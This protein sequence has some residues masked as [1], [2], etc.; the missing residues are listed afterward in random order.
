MGQASTRVLEL[1][2]GRVERRVLT[3][4]APKEPITNQSE[5][6]ASL[7]KKK[8]KKIVESLAP[9]LTSTSK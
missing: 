7:P 6:Q 9:V 8:K 1:P 3:S 4:V 5:I 2:A